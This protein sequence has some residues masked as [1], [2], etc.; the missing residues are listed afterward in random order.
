[1]SES[2][3]PTVGFSTLELSHRAHGRVA[4]QA[5]TSTSGDT[6]RREMRW[7]VNSDSDCDVGITLTEGV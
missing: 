3:I 5:V 4:P 2:V 7:K 1:M 6:D